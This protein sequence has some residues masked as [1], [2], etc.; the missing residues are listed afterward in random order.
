[1]KPPKSV[2]STNP[3]VI[4][5]IQSNKVMPCNGAVVL[6]PKRTLV[7]RNLCMLGPNYIE[8]IVEMS[9]YHNKFF[10]LAYD[11]FTDK[12]HVLELH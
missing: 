8:C 4:K 9:H 1:M 7:W 5:V 6:P 11:M 2:Y 12:H 3:K 10:I